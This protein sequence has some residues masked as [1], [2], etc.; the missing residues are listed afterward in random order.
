MTLEA[1]SERTGI[2]KSTLSRTR[3]WSTRPTLEL[4]LAL[5]LTYRCR[6]TTW[7]GA[8]VGT[9]GSAA[10]GQVKGRT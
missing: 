9:L 3:D 6:S 4:L 1:V 8:E 5:S 7:W 10:P 2:S